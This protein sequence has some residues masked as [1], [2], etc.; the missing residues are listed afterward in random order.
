[1][2]VTGMNVTHRKKKNFLKRGCVKGSFITFSITQFESV[3]AHISSN[4]RQLVE[5]LA[6]CSSNPVMSLLIQMQNIVT[7]KVISYPIRFLS[8]HF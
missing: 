4:N 5:S 1:M 2:C 6:R 3:K 8:S 7:F